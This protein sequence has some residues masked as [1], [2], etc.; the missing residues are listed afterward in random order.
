MGGILFV[1]Y[2]PMLTTIL[3]RDCIHMFWNMEVVDADSF[4][5]RARNYREIQLLS[6]LQNEVQAGVPMTIL[7]LC[8][9]MTLPMN[10]VLILHQPWSFENMLALMLSS[11]LIGIAIAGNMFILGGHAGLWSDSK[12][13]ID[14]LVSYGCS[15]HGTLSQWEW[16]WQRKFWR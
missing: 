2:V 5:V 1:A 7:M 3:L 15:K 16:K 4:S 13:L 8:F 11:Y 12:V 14:K 10:L 9:I 6:S